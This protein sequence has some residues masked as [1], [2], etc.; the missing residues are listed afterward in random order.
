MEL[1][2]NR[3]KLIYSFLLWLAFSGAAW[4][5]TEYTIRADGIV[6]PF[7]AYSVEKQF[8]KIDGVQAVEVDLEKG[9]VFV[10]TSDEVVFTDEQ[11]SDLFAD[12][13]FT[14]R[15]IENQVVKRADD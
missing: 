4:S 10:T 1:M 7:C 8:R 15:G 6:C 3:K 14:Y 9:E 5:E 11:L 12:A 13:G 2:M